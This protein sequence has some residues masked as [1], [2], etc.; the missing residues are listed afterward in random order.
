MKNL[1]L[2][3]STNHKREDLLVFCRSL[4]RV[5]SVEECDLVIC[6]NYYEDYFEELRLEGVSFFSSV[7]KFR[8]H[9]SVGMKIIR[10]IVID[11]GRYGKK[12]GLTRRL[13]PE[14]Q[15]AYDVI[16]ECWHH[17]HYARWYA[18]RRFMALN[19][20]YNQVLL[21]DV[22]DIAFQ[23][24]FFEA[25]R[26][27]VDLFT[28]LEPYGPDSGFN[29]GWYRGAWGDKALERAKGKLPVCIG[30][31]LGPFRET[32]G[33]V[34]EIVDFFSAHPF[35]GV[36]QA[37]FNYMLVEDML[38]TPVTYVDNITG[39][40][41]TLSSDAAKGM[42]HVAGGTVRRA[43]N[44]SVIPI[45]HMYDRFPDTRNLYDDLIHQV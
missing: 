19:R 8:P 41:A 31:I 34:K 12:L 7:N 14:A 1:V 45:V 32:Y 38:Q 35:H 9:P 20:H 11:G 2:A 6:T 27:K 21:A 39:P 43:A 23:D 16:M 10:R 17:P 4:R 42:T 40:V 30:T 44:G 25:P 15:S 22:R 24:R 18:Y 5:Y 33:L 29:T 26:E 13:P 3:F 37:V 28:E 36:E